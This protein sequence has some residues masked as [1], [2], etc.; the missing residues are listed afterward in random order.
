MAWYD[1]MTWVSNERGSMAW[2]LDDGYS[3]GN[4]QIHV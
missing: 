3:S 4:E 1:E 2:R